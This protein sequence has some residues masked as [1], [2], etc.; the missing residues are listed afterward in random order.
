VEREANERD[1]LLVVPLVERG[2]EGEVDAPRLVRDQRLQSFVSRD[3][4]SAAFAVAGNVT[5]QSVERVQE[6][7]F[8]GNDRR[9]EA[10]APKSVGHACVRRRPSRNEPPPS[11]FGN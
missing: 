3:D 10:W 2:F 6:L 4:L 7:R 5:H 11:R 1:E 9:V 8:V